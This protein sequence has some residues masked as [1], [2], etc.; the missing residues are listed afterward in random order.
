MENKKEN[1]VF[2]IFKWIIYSILILILIVNFYIILQS[3][4]SKDKVPSV[5]GYKPFIVLSGSMEP[6]IRI[7]DLIFVKKANIESLKV[8][9]VIAFRDDDK[10][11]TT[12]RII[13]IDTETYGQK[14]FITKGDSNNVKDEILTCK[15]NL[16]GLYTSRIP[17]IGKIIMFIQEPLGFAVLMLSIFIICLFIY[18]FENKQIDKKY[19]KLND[20]DLKAFEEFKKSQLKK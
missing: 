14:C 19:T 3:K 20:E 16:E 5:F 9:D 1:K 10:T 12:H 11:V 8:N 4:A 15:N 6:N 7:G 17:K 2:K 13:G 18:L